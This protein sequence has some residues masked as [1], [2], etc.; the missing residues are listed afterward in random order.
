MAENLK[1]TSY[2][3]G[4]ASSNETNNSEWANL[5]S[6][7]WCSYNNDDG[8]VE[9]YGLLYNWYAVD[10][11]RNIAPSGW[12][13]PTDEEWKELEIYLGMSQTDADNTNFRGTD[14]GGKMKESG[15]THWNSPNTGATNESG[16]TALPG[17]YRSNYSGTFDD[18]GYGGGWWSST[19]SGSYAWH[20]PYWVTLFQVSAA[21]TTLCKAAL[22]CGV[23]GIRLLDYLTITAKRSKFFWNSILV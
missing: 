16:F 2:R 4:E 17:G 12:H 22:V 3:N 15:T 9:T 21:T 10:D 5:S 20:R 23:F 18:I 19:G 1:V 11:S 6:G 8:N 13:V 14:E 7:A